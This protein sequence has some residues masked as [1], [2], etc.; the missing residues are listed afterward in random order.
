MSSV[1]NKCRR[2]YLLTMEKIVYT[3]FLPYGKKM[4]P[5]V[6]TRLLRVARRFSLIL[7]DIFFKEL[8]LYEKKVES[9]SII[10]FENN[11]VVNWRIKS[12]KRH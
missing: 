7:D 3:L 2:E 5:L 11:G 6:K 8:S 12:Q 4:H 9:V 1:D 10:F